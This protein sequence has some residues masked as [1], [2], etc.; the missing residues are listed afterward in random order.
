VELDFSKREIES[1]K[2]S[3]D[4]SRRSFEEGFLIR[5]VLVEVGKAEDKDP[6]F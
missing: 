5:S 4:I 3:R 6:F 2:L 1:R